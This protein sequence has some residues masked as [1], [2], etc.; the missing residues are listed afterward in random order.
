MRS[1]PNTHAASGDAT[2]APTDRDPRRGL[3]CDAAGGDGS[4]RLRFLDP[5]TF[6]G[7]GSRAVTGTLWPSLFEIELARCPELHL[8]SIGFETDTTLD[9][10]ATVP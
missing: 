6:A 1:A 2:V 3:D 8:V 7:E 10:S 4:S 5:V 9:W